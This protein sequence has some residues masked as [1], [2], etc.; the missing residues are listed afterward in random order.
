MSAAT[1]PLSEKN[2]LSSAECG[3]F[4]GNAT[5]FEELEAIYG[6]KLLVPLRTLGNGS[7]HYNKPV[8][9]GVL[10]KAHAEGVLND[11]PRVEKALEKLRAKRKVQADRQGKSANLPNNG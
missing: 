3:V 7:R 1:I 8:V 4:C 10:N 11:R 2:V 6:D 9:I 5:I